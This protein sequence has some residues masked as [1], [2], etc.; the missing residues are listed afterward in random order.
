MDAL[1]KIEILLS[2]DAQEIRE[3]D[4]QMGSKHIRNFY[5]TKDKKNQNMFMNIKYF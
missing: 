5:F 4:T 3:K 1:N 2:L